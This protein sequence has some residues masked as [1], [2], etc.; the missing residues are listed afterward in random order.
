MLQILSRLDRLL[1]LF[2]ELSIPIASSAN[3]SQ[4]VRGAS[5]HDPVF[6]L[7]D[8]LYVIFYINVI[9]VLMKCSLV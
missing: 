3:L 9:Q 1:G 4:S 6:D 2:E 5:T 8:N 7:K